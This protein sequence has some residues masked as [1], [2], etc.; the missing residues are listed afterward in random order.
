MVSLDALATRYHVLPSQA[1][2]NATTF[3]L[4]VLDISSRYQHYRQQVA[5]GKYVKPVKQL[6][7]Q[8]MLAMLA[9]VKERKSD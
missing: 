8:E 9:K 4:Y 1:M 6:S 5:E 7:E 2:K 3:D